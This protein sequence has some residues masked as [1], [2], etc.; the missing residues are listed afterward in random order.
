[1]LPG[2]R[3]ILHTGQALANR[4]LHHCTLCRI[5]STRG[6]SLC[7]RPKGFPPLLFPINC[8]TCT[9]VE[10]HSSL[11][12]IS[13]SQLKPSVTHPLIFPSSVSSLSLN[14]HDSSI[15]PG[16]TSTHVYSGHTLLACRY[17]LTVDRP[18]LLSG[19]R[20]LFTWHTATPRHRTAQYISSAQH[21][22]TEHPEIN[23]N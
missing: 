2:S 23:L 4:W 10:S 6:R 16:A 15:K 9:L 12:S 3:I 5:S 21:C 20:H 19:L 14:H 8:F 11:V 1:M 17:G 13:E 22:G 7:P 18:L